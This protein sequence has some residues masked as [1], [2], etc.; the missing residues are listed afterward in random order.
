MNVEALFPEK[1]YMSGFSLQ[2]TVLGR[3][4][5][6]HHINVKCN[7]AHQIIVKIQSYYFC[8]LLTS[9]RL[10]SFTDELTHL[11][12]YLRRETELKRMQIFTT[13]QPFWREIDYEIIFKIIFAY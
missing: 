13:W 12:P 10:D 6:V 11:L 3:Y 7:V 4:C 9:G 2:C 5:S 1:E 8:I